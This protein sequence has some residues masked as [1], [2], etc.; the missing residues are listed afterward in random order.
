V[1]SRRFQSVPIAD[2]A[3][4][5]DSPLSWLAQVRPAAMTRDSPARN[6]AR[7]APAGNGLADLRVELVLG[8]VSDE[9]RHRD[10][11]RPRLGR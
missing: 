7:I 10:C 3:D 6:S 8:A 11:R 5:G 2:E 4:C 1:F 9:R